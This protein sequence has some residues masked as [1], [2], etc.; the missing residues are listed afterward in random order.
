MVRTTRR[1]KRAGLL[2]LDVNHLVA[3][4]KIDKVSVSPL[5]EG[6]P[7]RLVQSPAA[8]FTVK[9]GPKLLD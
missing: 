6:P 4:P 9:Q 8:P 5:L 3:A 2:H 1:S 7:A